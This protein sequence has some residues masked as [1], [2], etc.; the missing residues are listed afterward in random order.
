MHIQCLEDP[1]EAIIFIK[2]EFFKDTAICTVKLKSFSS[3]SKTISGL[4]SLTDIKIWNKMQ[5]LILD[6]NKI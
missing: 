5:I 4:L 2:K 1:A 3:I 6:N